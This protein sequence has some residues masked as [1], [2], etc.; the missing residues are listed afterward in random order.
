MTATKMDETWN[1]IAEHDTI[2]E[3]FGT[4]R[5][6]SSSNS[7]VHSTPFFFPIPGPKSLEIC[8]SASIIVPDT[9]FYPLLV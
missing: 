1:V 9:C 4:V 3:L 2:L 5:R 6:D 8:A 7:F